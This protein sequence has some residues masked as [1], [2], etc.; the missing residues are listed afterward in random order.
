MTDNAQCVGAFG[1]TFDRF[2]TVYPGYTVE[3]RLTGGLFPMFVNNL[4]AAYPIHISKGPD[5]GLWMTDQGDVSGSSSSQ[6]RVVHINPDAAA[7]GFVP[8]VFR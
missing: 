6:G 7:A 3:F 4:A 2:R 8:K 1:G 5:G